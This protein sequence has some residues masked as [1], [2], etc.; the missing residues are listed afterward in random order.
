MPW[1]LGNFQLAWARPRGWDAFQ[2][3]PFRQRR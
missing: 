3:L 1:A 2:D